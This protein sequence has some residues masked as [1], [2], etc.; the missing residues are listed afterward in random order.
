M[1]HYISAYTVRLDTELFDSD[2]FA[3]RDAK[4]STARVLVILSTT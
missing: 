3:M 2:V 4:L 1:I